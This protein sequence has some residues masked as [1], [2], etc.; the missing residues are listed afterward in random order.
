MGFDLRIFG[1]ERLDESFL[2]WLTKEKAGEINR[3]FGRMWDYY[4]NTMA[5][6]T[7]T[8]A[9]SKAAEAGRCY[10]QAQEAGLP[11]RITGV[12]RNPS[13][14]VF[15]GRAV[16]QIQRKEVVIENDIA[17]RINATVDFLFG[18]PVSFVSRSPDAEIYGT[19]A[20]G[21]LKQAKV[22]SEALKE[23]VQGNE[24]FKKLNAN[25]VDAFKD[26]QKS[27]SPQTRQIVTEMK[28]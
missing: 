28:G 2:E 4:V 18:K 5:E 8:G 24:L 19:K 25:S 26:A 20:V 1:D 16:G 27:Q 23:I 7:G 10:V 11:A 13:A 9:A 14:G 15:G 17:W 12:L 22:K 3:H 6:T 21:F